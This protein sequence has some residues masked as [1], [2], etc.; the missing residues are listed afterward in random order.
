[1]KQTLVIG[2]AV[3]D[4]IVNI[5]H[6]PVTGEDVHISK[7][8]R[9]L[10][11]CAYLTSDILRHFLAPYSLCT[12][13][14]GGIYGNFVLE[15]LKERGVT[16][17][18]RRGEKEN[19]CCYCM[20]E[21]GGERTFIVDHGIEYTFHEAYLEKIHTKSIDSVY[22]CGLEIEETTGTNIIDYLRKH[23]EYEIYFSPSPRIMK[24]QA[25]RMAAVLALHPIVHLNEKELLEF[26]NES[27]VE[28]GAKALHE[29]TQR[30]V[31]VTLG[32][33][34]AYC[35]DGEKDLYAHPVKTTVVDTIGAGDSHM[36]AVIAARRFGLGF[37]E[38]IE[39]ANYISAAVVAK[40]GGLLEKEDFRNALSKMP[41]R[42]QQ[43][44]STRV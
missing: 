43:K 25:E 15:K 26:T 41:E 17:Y 10:G 30:P 31:I 22:I 16:I 1:M 18:V 38:A 42:L 2:S 39:A 28:G 7:Q 21:E 32:E 36:G 3:V 20:V 6:L 12:A 37:G 24:I 27:S 11:G 9:S 29:K 34:G 19:G 5:P 8:S 13:V 4:V 33:K 35:F 14:G 23:P 40:S 44:F